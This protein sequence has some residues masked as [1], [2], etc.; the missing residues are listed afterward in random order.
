M[1]NFYLEISYNVLMIK[2]LKYRIYPTHKQQTL[3]DI[4]LEEMRWLYNHCLAERKNA[5]EQTGKSPGLYDQQKTFPQLKASRPTLLNC[6]AQSLQNVAVRVDLAFQAY[7]RRVKAG[8][9]EVG[10][11]RFKG[12]GRYDSITFPQAESS[13]E[14]KNGKL[15]VSKIG[16][17]TIKLHRPIEG[18]VKTATL[19]RSSTG[20]WYVCFSLEVVPK[21]L[22]PNSKQVGIDVGLKTFASMSDGTEIANPRFFR[23]EEN[24][25]AKVQRKLSKEVKGTPE[26]R[27]R[28]KAVARVHERT[29][30]KRDNFSHQNS[31][32]IVNSF[33][34]IAVEDLNVNRMVHNHCLSKSIH[35]AAWSGFF[36]MLRSKAEEAGYTFIAV[37]PAYTSQT[38]SKC[39]H[40]RL[41][42]LTLSERVFTCP[43]CSLH[44][45]RDLNA[46]LNILALGLQGIRPG[47]VEAVCFS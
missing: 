18:K 21:R 5:Y 4:Q 3:L 28:G 42:K 14:V 39:G 33:G 22:P 6:N 32:K 11:P 43:E 12:Y 45:D 8:E 23:K 9:K 19:T 30:W 16:N 13:C 38:C 29:G 34:L 20:K 2:A 44:L 27:F 17:V 25:L 47:P 1:F 15:K 31:R 46:S 10:Y 36:S 37:N 40:R 26:R 7:F 24:E 41:D 35:D